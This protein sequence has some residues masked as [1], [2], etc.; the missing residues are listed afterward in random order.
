MALAARLHTVRLVRKLQYQFTRHWHD[1]AGSRN[2]HLLP[3]KRIM[4]WLQSAG[5]VGEWCSR[6]HI[7]LNIVSCCPPCIQWQLS[8]KKNRCRLILDHMLT[9]SII[10]I[11]KHGCNL[12]ITWLECHLSQELR[13]TPMLCRICFK[14]FTN[15]SSA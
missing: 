10:I 7:S 11:L 3:S 12:Y 4:S 14:Q 15:N 1:S 13:A 6:T 8:F 9:S 2:P 5:V